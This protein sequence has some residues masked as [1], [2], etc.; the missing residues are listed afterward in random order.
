MIV[1]RIVGPDQE[2]WYR[3]QDRHGETIAF[4]RSYDSC[5]SLAWKELEAGLRKSFIDLGFVSI[6]AVHDDVPSAP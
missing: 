3:A 4:G 5:A 2:G 1:L 6:R